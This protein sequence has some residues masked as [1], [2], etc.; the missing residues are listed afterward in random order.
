LAV[1]FNLVFTWLLYGVFQATVVGIIF[2]KMS[3]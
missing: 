2:A 1:S 3:P